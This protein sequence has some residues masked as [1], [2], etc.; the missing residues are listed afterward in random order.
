[1]NLHV[2]FSLIFA[3]V[4]ICVMAIVSTSFLLVEFSMLLI[5]HQKEKKLL[6]LITPK[7]LAVF[8]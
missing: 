2:S 5:S 6:L 8:S 7:R 4:G 3:F 1:M